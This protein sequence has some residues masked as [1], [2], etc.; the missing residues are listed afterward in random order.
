[1]VGTVLISSQY[2][3]LLFPLTQVAEVAD[4]QSR[5][6]MFIDDTRKAQPVVG[7][8]PVYARWL[9]KET[10]TA[11]G[12]GE[13]GESIAFESIASESSLKDKWPSCP[14]QQKECSGVASGRP[15]W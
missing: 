14:H 3:I 8:G 15:W 1:M 12:H 7:V 10:K 11:D 2:W 4:T 9:D 6:I 5:G 13:P